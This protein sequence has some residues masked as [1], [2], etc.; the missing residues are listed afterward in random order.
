MINGCIRK[1]SIMRMTLRARLWSCY[2]RTATKY[3]GLE[4]PHDPNKDR[5]YS[6]RFLVCAVYVWRLRELATHTLCDIKT[7][8]HYLQHRFC[9]AGK[10]SRTPRSRACTCHRNISKVLLLTTSIL[11]SGMGRERQLDVYS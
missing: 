10:Q 7:R 5:V 6:L 11:C 1:R 4:T 9:F 3:L 8:V 2:E